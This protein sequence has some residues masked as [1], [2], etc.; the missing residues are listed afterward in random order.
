MLSRVATPSRVLRE[1]LTRARQRLVDP[2]D[3]GVAPEQRGRLE[4]ARRDRAAGNRHADRLV[5]LAGLH[6]ELLDQRR[7]R[8]FAPR[9]VE[10]L[11]PRERLACAREVLGCAVL[12]H[13]RPRLLVGRALLVEPAGERL[14]VLERLHLLLADRSRRPEPLAPGMALERARQVGAVHLA[15]VAAVH[16]AQLLLV[17]DGRAL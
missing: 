16:P 17:E 9:L 8:G 6:V 2:L 12:H 14:E 1:G 10:R 7:E 4:D 11:Y 5:E 15:H 3:R 13:L